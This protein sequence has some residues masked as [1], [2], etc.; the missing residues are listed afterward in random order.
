MQTTKCPV[1]NSDVVI[2]DEAVD[3]DMAECVICK[4]MLEVHLH[5]LH[6]TIIEEN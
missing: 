2:D 4:V 6:L 3:G 1:C 5:P